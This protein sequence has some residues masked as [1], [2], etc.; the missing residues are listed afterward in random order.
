MEGNRGRHCCSQVC[1]EVHG[2]EIF[3]TVITEH[4]TSETAEGTGTRQELL[5]V[6]TKDQFPQI[7]PINALL[8]VLIRSLYKQMPLF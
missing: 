8:S 4:G 7:S 5:V 1:L 6:H 2:S 3:T